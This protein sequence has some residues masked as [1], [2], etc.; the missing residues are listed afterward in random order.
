MLYPKLEGEIRRIAMV[1]ADPDYYNTIKGFERGT[2]FDIFDEILDEETGSLKETLK[3][4]ETYDELNKVGNLSQLLANNPLLKEKIDK[5]ILIYFDK[6]EEDYNKDLFDPVFG[7]G[8]AMPNSLNELVLK[9][10]GN[11]KE[12]NNIYGKNPEDKDLNIKKAAIRS[13]MINN[14]IHKTETTV[15]LQG[16]GFQFDHTKDEMSK[17]APGSQSGG[18]T[19][20][21]DKL[22]KIFIDAKVG[23]PYEQKLIADKVISP[24]EVRT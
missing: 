4:K 16:D 2:E 12:L 7:E 21:V 8:V 23:R 19:F 11:K 14:F 1:K 6:T 17:R 20:P 24:K 15:F 18:T 22:T 5:E 9:D 13:Y 3:S 10:L